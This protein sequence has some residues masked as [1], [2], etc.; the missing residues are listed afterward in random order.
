MR[1]STITNWAYAVTVVLTVLSGGAFILSAHSA[2]RER[3]AV[4]TRQRL[5]ELVDQLALAAEQTTE[6]ARLFVMR[7]E[8]RHLQAFRGAQGEERAREEAI[9]GLKSTDLSPQ[10]LFALRRLETDAEA[11]DQIEEKAVADYGDGDSDGARQTLFG[12]EH[13]RLQTDLLTSVQHFIDLVATRAADEFAGARARTDLWDNIAKSMLGLTAAVFIGVLYFVLKRR[14]ATPL[15]RMTGIVNRLAKQDY[16]V[17]VLP[18]SRRDEIGEMNEAIQIFR[19]NGLE[20]ERLDA[21][22]RRD[23]KTKDHILQMMHRLQACQQHEELAEVVSLFAP[24]IFP[25][26]AGQLYL[27]NSSRSALTSASQWRQP[28]RSHDILAPAECWGLRR[29]RPHVSDHSG[30]DVPCQHLEAGDDACICIPLSAQGDTVGLLYFEGA[31]GGKAMESAR[32]YI[33]II[34]EN[35]GLAIANLQLRDR[36]THLAVRDPLTGLLNRRSLDDEMNRLRRDSLDRPSACLMVDIDH[37]KHFNDEFGHDAGDHVMRQVATL[38]TET[39][40][41]SGS[42]YR[43]GGEEFTIIL[44]ESTKDAGFGI[45]EKLR[46]EVEAT[47]ITYQGR[48]LGT[49]TVSIGIA[50]TEDGKPAATLLQRADAALLRA[51]SEGRNITLIEGSGRSPNHRLAG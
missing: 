45:A 44:P 1:I 49:V 9:K 8:E 17:E 18:D 11:L 15:L 31:D 30:G 28:R 12:P 33:E 2:V 25:H 50:S 27:M 36:L 13:E 48:P 23:Q 37:F 46:T 32:L 47:P 5:D 43:F 29:G 21:E 40:G 14:V 38:M 22:R 6:D 35:I 39:A 42:V 16:D 20:R 24:R 3:A 4:E 51:K 7:G 26:L 19:D 10:E 34:A 41:K